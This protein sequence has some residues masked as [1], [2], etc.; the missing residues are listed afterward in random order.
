MIYAVT[1]NGT[2]YFKILDVKT[3][4]YLRSIKFDSIFNKKLSH[5]NLIDADLSNLDFSDFN[6]RGAQLFNVN[7]NDCDL[8][9]VN[10]RL[11]NLENVDLSNTIMNEKTDFRNSNIA[12]VKM[13]KSFDYT[14]PMPFVEGKIDYKYRL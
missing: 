11:A 8:R 14:K 7:F 12:G 1:K 13:P 9:N 5:Y 6:F 2:E 4:Y 3:G 10:F